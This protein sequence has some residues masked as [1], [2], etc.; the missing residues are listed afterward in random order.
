MNK[1]MVCEEDIT[2][3]NTKSYSYTSP[4]CG[5]CYLKKKREHRKKKGL[6]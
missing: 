6:K 1:C 3:R 2:Q 4:I 5:K